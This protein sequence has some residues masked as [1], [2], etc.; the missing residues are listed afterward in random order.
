MCFMP[1]VFV[2]FVYRVIVPGV[3]CDLYSNALG[4]VLSGAIWVSV[5]LRKIWCCVKLGIV[6]G[7]VG[8]FYLPF[9]WLPCGLSDRGR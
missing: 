1:C 5:S 3:P 7:F 4:N 6:R 8:L 2:L 9:S